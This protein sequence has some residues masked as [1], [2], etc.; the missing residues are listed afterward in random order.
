MI[1]IPI[2]PKTQVSV[3][4]KFQTFLGT[5]SN[6]LKSALSYKNHQSKSMQS[7]KINDQSS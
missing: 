3:L 1:A 4:E 2:C 7:L 6:H 5:L